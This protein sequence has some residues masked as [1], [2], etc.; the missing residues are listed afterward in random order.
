LHHLDLDARGK[1]GD[2][3]VGVVVDADERQGVRLRGKNRIG[4][5]AGLTFR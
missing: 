4:E 5:S 1:L 3:I 2:E